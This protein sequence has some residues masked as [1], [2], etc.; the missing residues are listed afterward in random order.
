MAT[1]FPSPPSS[2]SPSP[3]SRSRPVSPS[4][5]SKSQP[6]DH[7]DCNPLS[8]RLDALLSS[9]LELLDTYTTLREQLSKEFSSGFLALAQANRNSTLGPGR[10]YGEEG[11]DERMKALRVVRLGSAQADWEA[12]VESEPRHQHEHATQTRPEA[13]GES[14]VEEKAEEDEEKK[15]SFLEGGE[16]DEPET[17]V[18]STHTKESSDSGVS[19][20]DDPTH[21]PSHHHSASNDSTYTFTTF[22]T[23]TPSPS[24]LS[25]ET[26]APKDPLKWY[27]ILTP[28]PLRQCQSLFQ[29]SMTTTIAALLTTTS[30]LDSLEAEIWDV[31]RRLGLLD[32]YEP[33]G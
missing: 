5:Q 15:S 8:E 17:R 18:K 23:T 20:Q 1:H 19:S 10:R 24:S 13:G 27:G 12:E 11:Y 16:G 6:R 29:S 4:F 32:E 31:R 22:T 33:Q 28:P 7:D 21:K 9:Y 2:R 3:Y 25:S 30:R 14:I 26:P